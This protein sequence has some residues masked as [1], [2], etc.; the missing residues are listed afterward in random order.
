MPRS[1]LPAHRPGRPSAA[2]FLA[3]ILARTGNINWINYRLRRSRGVLVNSHSCNELQE[4]RLMNPIKRC[5]PLLILALAPVARAQDFTNSY[6]DGSSWNSIYAQGFSPSVAPVPNPGFPAGATV[7][8][9]AFEFF[10]SGSADNLTDIRLAIINPL[11]ADITGLSTSHPAFVGL[12]ANTITGTGLIPIGAP[13]SFSF[14]NIP[15]TYGNNYAAVYVNLGA[16]GALT[17]VLVPSLVADYIENPPGSGTFRPETNYGAENQFDYAVSNFITTNQFGM[18]FNTFSFAADAN[19]VATFFIPEPT[20]V[21]LTLG[22]V[23]IA[24]WRRRRRQ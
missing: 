8:L 9:H 24:V 5:L 18:F 12:S 11:F 17:P 6:L 2:N 1:D 14:N 16:G 13:I 10:K 19:F 22:G 21:S 4:Y 23:A 20:A 3:K 15:L 7:G